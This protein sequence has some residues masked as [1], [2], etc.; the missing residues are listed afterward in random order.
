M[1]APLPLNLGDELSAYGVL[2]VT[3]L[4]GEPTPATV[5]YLDLISEDSDQGNGANLLPDAVAEN[6]GRPL[7]YVVN[8]A[9]LS[10]DP[11]Q[12]NTDLGSVRRSLGSRGERAF[13]GIIEPGQLTVA[14][15]SLDP[16]LPTPA[17]YRTA[18]G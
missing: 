8:K 6:Q 13:L 16:N 18:T 17:I 11:A 7:L 4:R 14:P 12:Y 3:P 5:D 9:H 1:P 10:S 2:H 15:I